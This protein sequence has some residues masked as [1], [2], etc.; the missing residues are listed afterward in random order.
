MLTYI[1]NVTVNG[2][3]GIDK[4]RSP[5]LISRR[6]SNRCRS[7]NRKRNKQILDERGAEGLVKWV[8]D[9][10]EVLLTDTTFRDAHQSLL[11]TRVRTHD[12]K[13]RQSDGC[14]LAR[15]FQS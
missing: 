1:G 11:A 6:S 2:F 9:Q 3:P 8:K 10:E 5:S 14:A 13:N 12:L 15:A 4:R 7:A